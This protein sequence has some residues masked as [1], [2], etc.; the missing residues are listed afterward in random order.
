M[1]MEVSGGFVAS[2]LVLVAGM[3]G[4]AATA[5]EIIEISRDVQL[6]HLTENVWVHTTFAETPDYGRIPANGLVVVDANEAM[7]IDLPW[8][9]ELTARLLDWMAQNWQVTVRTVVPT[10][11]HEDCMGGLTEAHRR[12]I[13]SYALDKT[14]ALAKEKEL[15]VPQHAFEKDLS[16]R[17]GQTPVELRYFGAGHTTDNIIAWLPRQQVLF[18]GCLIKAMNAR[19]LGNTSE[20]NLNVYPATLRKVRASYPEAQVVVPGHGAWGPI[21]LIDHTLSLC[22]AQRR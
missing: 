18:G 11:F 17:C 15:P 14:V 12:G 2:F 4:Y 22:P 6:R 16:L 21:E 1:S 13:T 10:H 3:P 19:S 20:G 8:T 7:L 9:D 5:P